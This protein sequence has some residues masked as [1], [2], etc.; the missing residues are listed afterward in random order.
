M[1]V[2]GT[3]GE[4]ADFNGPNLDG[5]VATYIWREIFSVTENGVLAGGISV[6][7]DRAAGGCG[8]GVSIVEGGGGGIL[9]IWWHLWTLCILCWIVR[10]RKEVKFKTCVF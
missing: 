8:C 1:A 3:G 9:G 6:E 4:C 10:A 2:V 7:V 5:H